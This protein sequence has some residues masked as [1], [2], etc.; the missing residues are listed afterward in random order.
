MNAAAADTVANRFRSPYLRSMLDLQ[1]GQSAD[2]RPEP[3][4]TLEALWTRVQRQ[5]SRYKTVGRYFHLH[6]RTDH[7]FVQ[8]VDR[9]HRGKLAP[10]F[11]MAVGEKMLCNDPFGTEKERKNLRRRLLYLLERG[12]YIW[13][14]QHADGQRYFRCVWQTELGGLVW[15]EQPRPMDDGSDLQNAKVICCPMD[16][17]DCKRDFMRIRA[18]IWAGRTK[19]GVPTD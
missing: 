15:S 3:G 14:E 8:R 6:K 19:I 16:L 17:V 10:F 4:D 18:A 5:A 2:L 12:P 9:G 13:V 1:I 7:I 11:R